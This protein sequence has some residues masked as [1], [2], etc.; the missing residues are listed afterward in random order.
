MRIRT[1]AAAAV[2]VAGQASEQGMKR[3]G[4]ILVGIAV[5]GGG[6][7]GATWWAGQETERQYRLWIGELNR[8]QQALRLSGERYQ[9]GW[10]QSEAV[11]RI[12][13]TPA[14]GGAPLVFFAEHAIRHGPLP[15]APWQQDERFAPAVGAMR[16]VLRLDPATSQKLDG[17]YSGVE[18]AELSSLL[19]FGGASRHGLKIAG[20]SLAD[21]AKGGRFEFSG[22]QGRFELGPD[23]ATLAGTLAGEGLKLESPDGDHA[24]LQ[25]LALEFDLKRGAEGVW[26]GDT[27]LGVAQVSIAGPGIEIDTRVEG[28]G[29]AQRTEAR[30][31]GLLDVRQTWS[32]AQVLTDGKPLG[33]GEL[34]LLARNLHVPSLQALEPENLAD[35][36]DEPAA[37]QQR[38]L[39]LAAPVL[40]H[41]PVFGIERLHLAIEG[42]PAP[43]DAKW[44]FGLKAPASALDSPQAWAELGDSADIA[45]DIPGLKLGDADQGVEIDKFA[46]RFELTPGLVAAR[47]TGGAAKIALRGHGEGGFG[48]LELEG[49]ELAVDQTRGANGLL[50]GPARLAL[51]R[52]QIRGDEEPQAVALTKLVIDGN[53][54]EQGEYVAGRSKLA[55]GELRLGDEPLGGGELTL[56]FER[57]YGPALRALDAATQRLSAPFQPT[58]EA[59]EALAG[60]LQQAALKLLEHKPVLKLE[61]VRIDMAGEPKPAEAAAVLQFQ[62]LPGEAL[63][64]GAWPLQLLERG[65]AR[66][67][68]P[69][70]F[71]RAALAGSVRSQLAFA[72]ELAEMEART[73]GPGKRPV[74]VA[75]PSFEEALDQAL[76][77]QLAP[78]E[79]AGFIRRDE[80][81]VRTEARL[82]HG[83]LTLNGTELPLE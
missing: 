68:L 12:E 37:L 10:R 73:A 71:I 3:I 44:L 4:W 51:G 54:S 67:V 22:I 49:L 34:V 59:S 47:A 57:L 45:F 15:L 80:G 16:T 75:L 48:A 43:I 65:E 17:L 62:T 26:S 33:H 63:E 58:P 5:L 7:A 35:W 39:E 27:G 20:T 79:G 60:E 32:V 13:F 41:K 29:L 11:T 72:A 55:L 18:A 31:A 64:S 40:A 52:L 30:A 82:E 78:L 21:P 74:P 14:D 83:R 23:G 70:A 24:A 19:R 28:L 69:E 36:P 9:R 61:G 46:L 38:L 66:L 53:G 2:A 76:E 1:R 25:G 6:Y 81:V 56:V 8:E 42:Q 50:L 77:G